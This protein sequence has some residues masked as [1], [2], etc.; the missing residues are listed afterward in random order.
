MLCNFRVIY[1]SFTGTELQPFL[2]VFPDLYE[3]V[4]LRASL[5][6]ADNARY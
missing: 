3:A 4:L 1:R 2:F 6:G 5:V